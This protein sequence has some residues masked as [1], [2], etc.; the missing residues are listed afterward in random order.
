[1]VSTGEARKLAM[2]L[3][4]T[5]ELPHFDRTSFRVKK[6]FMTM[7][8]DEQ[9]AVLM[10]TPEDQSVFSSSP[11][12][13]VYQM[14]NKWGLK[15]ATM[16]NLKKVKKGLLKDAM[17]CAWLHAASKKTAKQY[18]PDEASIF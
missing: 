6:I 7:K 17:K 8:E 16:V 11:D 2:Q 14:P 4:E 3:P 9:F 15:G 18:F 13:A 5:V 1:M 12:G 10:L